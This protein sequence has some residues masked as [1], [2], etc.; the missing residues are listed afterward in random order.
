MSL[1]QVVKLPKNIFLLGYGAMGKCFTE[2]LL[3]HFR[4]ANLTVCDFIDLQKEESRFKYIKMKVDRKNITNIF[5]HVQKG[6]ILVDLSTNIDFLDIWSMCN[7]NGVMYMN[8][9]ME[10]WDDSVNPNSFP[11]NEDELNRTSLGHRHDE[12]VNAK[13]WSPKS[14]IT[15]VFEHGM[16]PGLISHFMKKGL[17]DAGNYFLTRSDWKDLDK[18]KIK[19]HLKE[20]NYSKLA[21]ALGLHTI[22]GSEHDNQVVDDVP[23]NLK[24][25]F[26]NTWSCR[27][28]LTEGLVPIQVA[29]GSHEDLVNKDYPRVRKNTTI[30]SW[31][32]SNRH[33]GNS[34]I[35]IFYSKIMDSFPQYYWLTYSSRRIIY[36]SGIFVRQRNRIFSESILR[37]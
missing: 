15:S 1:N 36:Y 21:Q 23:K 29:R 37:L 4:N 32:P 5:S 7:K 16:N 25:K 20:K 13:F 14:G 19:K 9:A 28:F 33:W 34:Y 31:T 6:D 12:A 22:H 11:K 35:N 30:M 18:E 10:E 8:T 27:G 2:I 26:Y 24:T 3:K 17:L